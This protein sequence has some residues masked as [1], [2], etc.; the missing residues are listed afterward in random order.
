VRELHTEVLVVGGGVG[1][2]AAALAATRSG[3]SVILTEETD[4]LGGQLTSQAV[5][6]D[7][8]PWIE[9]FG[10]TQSYRM[11]RNSIRNYYRE[12]YPL[13]PQARSSLYLNPGAGKISPLCHEPRVALAAIESLLAPYQSSGL[14][15]VLLRCRPEAV[16]TDGDM[17]SAVTMSDLETGDE[18]T[19]IAPYVLDAT[20]TG[21]LLPLSRAE[22]VTGFESQRETGEPHAPSDPN[23]LNMQALTH[24]FA[25]DYSEEEDHKIDEPA[26]YEFWRGYRPSFWP[27]KQLGWTAP[28][29]RTLEPHTHTFSPNPQ[30]DPTAIVADQSVDPAFDD[31]WIFRRIVARFN[32]APGT[33]T[34]DIT[35]VNWPMIDYVGGPIFGVSEDEANEHRRAAK[36]LS[37]SLLY[38]LQTEAPRPDGGNGYPGLRLREDIVGTRDGL[39]K[40]PYVRESRRIRARYTVTEQDLAYDIRGER[41]AVSYIDSVGIG[42]FRIDLHPSTGGDNFVDIPACPFEIPLGALLPVRMENLLPAAK[43][44]G[45]TH[46]TNGCYRMHPVEWNVGEVSGLLANYCL[47]RKIRPHQVHSDPAHLGPFQ[48]VLVQQGIELRWPKAG[49]W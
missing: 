6:P 32:F 7:E 37:L 12:N 28:H 2:V 17:V 33:Y 48:E 45:T 40:R 23:P 8:H 35:L 41:G 18:L 36:Q 9:K 34:S 16:H 14:V 25:M 20:E 26:D 39:A 15:R 5:P 22:Y 44:I 43:N 10:C 24:C 29:P 1:G 47:R 42:S 30:G 49:G 3:S 19:I 38:W 11:L 27:G 21:E 46:I 31:L 13:M 4:W